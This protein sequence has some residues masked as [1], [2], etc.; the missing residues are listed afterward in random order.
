MELRNLSDENL[1]VVQ[2]LRGQYE[3]A[4][5]AILMAGEADGSFA[6]M[7]RKITVLSVLAQLTGVTIWYRDNGR[8]TQEQ[9]AEIYCD[10]VRRSVVA[11]P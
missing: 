11:K 1:A 3:D 2:S 4:L 6:Y 10:L 8:L 5:E 7:D 9:V